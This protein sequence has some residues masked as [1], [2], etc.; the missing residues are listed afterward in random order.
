[1]IAESVPNCF[2]SCLVSQPWWAF[3]SMQTLVEKARA[4][5]PSLDYRGYENRTKRRWLVLHRREVCAI[6]VG[7]TC[8]AGPACGNS[9]NFVGSHGWL[10]FELLVA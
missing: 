7:L 5:A 3:I 2:D 10:G 8:G 9:D 1:M 4:G 6:A